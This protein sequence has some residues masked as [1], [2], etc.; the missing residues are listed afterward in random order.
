VRVGRFVRAKASPFIK[1]GG[2]G[3]LRGGVGVAVGHFERGGV[4]AFAELFE[5]DG[6]FSE[7]DSSERDRLGV[8]AMQEGQQ[9]AHSCFR[10]KPV[11]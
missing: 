4:A 9:S 2:A 6:G 3:H 11:H 8:R 7:V 1:E 10:A 5:G